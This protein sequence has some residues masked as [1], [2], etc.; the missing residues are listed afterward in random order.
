MGR[1]INP[2]VVRL[3]LSQGDWI[4]IKERLTVG[5]QKRVDVS[6]LKRMHPT[7]GQAS[8]PI[9][10]DFAEFSFART[11]AYLVDWSFTGSDDKAVPVSRA[12]IEALT[13]ETYREI[14][15]A[16]TAHVEALTEAKKM[17]A[18]AGT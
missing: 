11:T 5:E 1:F 13:T 14:E 16:I 3:P 8:S 12:S 6:G 7:P 9:D 17:Q 15:D 4:E 2:V 10:T 18:G